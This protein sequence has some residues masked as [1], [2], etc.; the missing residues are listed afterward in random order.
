[1]PC[2]IRLVTHFVMPWW[3]SS[4]LLSI[5]SC[6]LPEMTSLWPL[7]ASLQLLVWRQSFLV[8]GHY[9]TIYFCQVGMKT[10]TGQRQ[11][12]FSIFFPCL[13]CCIFFRQGFL[14]KTPP[15]WKEEMFAATVVS[16]C[17]DRTVQVPLVRTVPLGLVEVM[18]FGDTITPAP[19]S[20]WSLMGSSVLCALSHVPH[21]LIPS[22][23][24]HRIDLLP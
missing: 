18:C 8:V 21:T 14:D 13:T 22:V 6:V 1:M 12:L 15:S 4:I 11:H 10:L 3:P 24:F 9:Q 20:V 17:A 23:C 16:L 2:K 5:S 7:I 19:K